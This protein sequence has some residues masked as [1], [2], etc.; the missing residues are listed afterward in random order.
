MTVIMLQTEAKPSAEMKQTT[1]PEFECQNSYLNWKK[2]PCQYWFN[3]KTEF[4]I[5]LST[6][7]PLFDPA[8]N[9]FR[10]QTLAKRVILGKRFF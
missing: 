4:H 10:L 1:L 5:P 7:F 8:L 9:P 2:F 6:L 3:L